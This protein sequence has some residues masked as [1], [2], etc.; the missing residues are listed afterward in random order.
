[1]VVV[2]AW[3]IAFYSFLNSLLYVTYVYDDVT[4][5]YDDVTYVYDDV[6]YVYE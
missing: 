6:T 5:V 3:C 1:V 4:Y 2:L